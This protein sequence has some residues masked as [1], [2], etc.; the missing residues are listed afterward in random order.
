M[1]GMKQNSIAVCVDATAA[2]WK[3][4]RLGMRATGPRGRAGRMTRSCW[5]RV[6][7]TGPGRNSSWILKR[8]CCRPSRPIG[9]S[10]PGRQCRW[11]LHGGCWRSAPEP[12]DH[13]HCSGDRN[14][15]DVEGAFR[16]AVNSGR[17]IAAAPRSDTPHTVKATPARHDRSIARA[18]ADALARS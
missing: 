18:Y 8:C 11:R 9:S 3:R 10:W 13:Q 1:F 2:W 14:A 16:S 4:R 12:R 5:G 6:G 15:G 7:G 17:F